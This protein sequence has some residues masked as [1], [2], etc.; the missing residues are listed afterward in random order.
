MTHRIALRNLDPDERELAEFVV[1]MY[2][3]PIG[4]LEQGIITILQDARRRRA[5][6]HRESRR[7]LIPTRRKKI[8]THAIGN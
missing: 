6:L 7:Q 5:D 1:E 8:D 3:E 2:R 4:E